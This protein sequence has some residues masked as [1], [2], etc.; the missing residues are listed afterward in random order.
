MLA[1]NEPPHERDIG[2]DV[3][4]RSPDYDP[5][6]DNIVRVEARNLRKQ[7]E[8]FFRVEGVNEPLIILIPKGSYAPVFERRAEPVP[9]LATTAGSHPLWSL[10]F[11]EERETLILIADSA[12]AALQD[13]LRV[14]IGLQDYLSGGFGARIAEQAPEP[15]LARTLLSYQLTSFAEVSLAFSIGRLPWARSATTVLRFARDVNVRDFEGKNVILLGGHRANPWIRLWDADL[16]FRFEYD[17]QTQATLIRNTAPRAGE[18]AAYEPSETN[19]V[20]IVALLPCPRRAGC[21]LWLA[22]TGMVGTEAAGSFVLDDEVLLKS[23]RDWDAIENG[24]A[25]PFEAVIQAPGIQGA[26]ARIGKVLTHRVETR[27]IPE[28]A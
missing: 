25:R 2:A 12:F 18:S 26:P 17:Q 14:D 8:E 23:L 3:Y 5:G 15:L 20:A 4:G 7:L 13:E 24:W 6:E 22:G 1:G 10:L 27:T 11:S 28:V 21:V 16:H 19:S 9:E